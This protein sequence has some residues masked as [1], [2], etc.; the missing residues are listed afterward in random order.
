MVMAMVAVAWYYRQVIPV[1]LSLLKTPLFHL[2]DLLWIHQLS[3]L[4]SI[5]PLVTAPTKAK[6]PWITKLWMQV[7]MILTE[8]ACPLTLMPM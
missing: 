3:T 4:L 8:E 1:T 6:S 2:W 7:R 5:L